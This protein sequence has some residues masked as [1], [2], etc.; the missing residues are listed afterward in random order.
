VGAYRCRP[1]AIVCAPLPHHRETDSRTH[2]RRRDTAVIWRRRRRTQAE[3]S[4]ARRSAA[5]Q[6]GDER[7]YVTATCNGARA[8]TSRGREGS[9]PGVRSRT[10]ARES[11]LLARG[12]ERERSSLFVHWPSA[13]PAGEE[14]RTAAAEHKQGAIAAAMGGGLLLRRCAR[15]RDMLGAAA[16]RRAC[17]RGEAVR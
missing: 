4:A 6:G 11:T 5:A 8:H 9:R 2:N 7:D 1:M 3:V 10:C 14:I 16:A 13:E 17:R 12:W 15:A